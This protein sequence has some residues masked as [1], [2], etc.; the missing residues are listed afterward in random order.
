MNG[1]PAS[2]RG[3]AL[4]FIF[5]TVVLDMMAFGIIAP[6]FP[7]LVLN[8]QG[9]DATRAAEILGIFG[10]AFAVMQFFFSPLLGML[11]D[12]FGRRPVILISTFGLGIDYI[13]MALAPNL[14]WLFAGRVISGITAASMTTAGAYIVDVTPAEKRA[15]GFGIIGAAFGIGFVLGPALGGFFGGLNPR[16]PFWI[17]AGFSLAGWLYGLL[18]LPESLPPEKRATR[19]SWARANPVGSLKLFASHRALLGLAAV[20]FIGYIGHLSLG[21]I[22]VLYAIYRY[23]WSQTTIGLSLALVGALT[24]VVSALAVKRAVARFG[25]RN[26]MLLGLAF[27]ASGFVLFGF[28]ANVTLFWLGIPFM[29]LFGLMGPAGQTMMS[30][31][32]KP[33]EQGEL[34]GAINSMR[35]IA[36]LIGPGLFTGTFAAFIDPHRAWQFPGAPWLLSALLMLTALAL[37][38][39]VTRSAVTSVV[40]EA[41]RA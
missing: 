31:L 16:L 18:V 33:H 30:H 5:I 41:Q 11:S 17:A 39:R 3:A 40:A 22:W 27:A 7:K 15:G 14:W 2:K 4:L 25:E 23:D 19:L 26:T 37:A 12:R 1:L 38:L 10:T 34:Q 29:A 21:N 35:A 20:Y 13:I 28:A 6:V 36:M 24:V 9:G 32:V 8:F